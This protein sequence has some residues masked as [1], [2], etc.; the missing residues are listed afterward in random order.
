MGSGR[1]WGVLLWERPVFV[2]FGG[3]GGGGVGVV[4]W[5]VVDGR[6]VVPFCFVLGVNGPLGI[7]LRCLNSRLALWLGGAQAVVCTARWSHALH[8]PEDL[9]L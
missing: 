8:R 3:W 2:G 6:G 5:E 4:G 1:V 9:H 7:G